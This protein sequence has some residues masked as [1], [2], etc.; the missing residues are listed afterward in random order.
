MTG[1]T[2]EEKELPVSEQSDADPAQADEAILASNGQ[3]AEHERQEVPEHAAVAAEADELAVMTDDAAAEPRAD[4]GAGP[5]IPPTSRPATTPPWPGT[6]RTS[7]PPLMRR[8]SLPRRVPP[9]PSPRPPLMARPTL[10]PEMPRGR[11]PMLMPG[12]RKAMPPM[13]RP[14][15]RP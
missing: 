2:S 3:A 13:R 5:R 1:K 4:D 9:R 6:P 10:T 8:L 14:Q 7:P 12:R 15:R 11:R